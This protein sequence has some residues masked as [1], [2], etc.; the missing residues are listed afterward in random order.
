MRDE[1]AVA[2][3]LDAFE[4]ALEPDR[5]DAETAVRLLLSPVGGADAVA[6]RR[7]RRALR[8]EE[9]AGRGAGRRTTCWSTPWPRSTAWSRS[10]RRSRCPR[11]G[12][13]ACSTPA[14]A[15]A[16]LDGATAE[17]VLWA[18]WAAAGLA[19]PWRR[20]ALSGGRAGARADRDLDAVV[21]LFDAAAR[22]VDRLPQAGPAGFLEHLRGQEVPGDTLVERAPAD[23]AV[24]LLTPAGRRRA[25]VAAR[26]RLRCPGGRLAGHP[27]ARLP[28]RVAGAGRRARR[29]AATARRRRCARLRR[30]S[31]RRSC[32]C[33]T[34]RS[35]GPARSSS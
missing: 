32:G 23:D 19:E 15:A 18:I 29:A 4:L 34:W 14:R 13:P 7:L 16:A 21:A 6:L 35:A 12:W 1:S 8:E 10:R 3:L 22:F 26:R 17:T 28:A 2:P 11:A 25:G 33:S 30:R 27:A 5:L 31:G 9:R 20:S 24:A